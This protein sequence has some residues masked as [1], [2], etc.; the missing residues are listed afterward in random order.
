MSEKRPERP[1]R[2]DDAGSRGPCVPTAAVP[3]RPALFHLAAAVG[4]GAARFARLRAVAL[5]PLAAADAALNRFG[6]SPLNPLYQTGAIAALAFLWMLASGVYLLFLYRVGAPYESIEA[7]QAQAFAGR[8]LRALHR[9]AADAAVIAVLL[10]VFRMWA[11]GRSFGPRALAWCSGLVLL[12]A[13]LLSGWTGYVMVWDAPAL[14]LARE[15]ARLLDALPI[16][17]EP[18]ARTFSG[19]RPMPSAFFFLNLFAHVAVPVGMAGLL[20]AHVARLAR[21]RLLPPRSLAIALSLAL[22][23]LALL[24]PSPLPPRAEPLALPRDVPLDAFYAFWL[25]LTQ[26]LEPGAAWALL[27]ALALGAASAPWWT[28]PGRGER[29]EPSSVDPHLCTGC[30][31]CSLDCPFDAIAMV[32][33]E[34]AAPGRSARFARVDP[35]RCVACGICAGSCAPMAVGPPGRTGRDQLAAARQLLHDGGVSTGDVV[36][37]AC[38]SGAGAPSE[39]GLAC[40]AI[41]CAGNLHSSLVELLVRSGV[42]GVLVASCPPRDCRS[43]EGPK[44]LGERLFHDREAELHARVPRER[45][46]VV[47]ASAG[48]P[49][50]L[51]EALARFRAELAALARARPE[52]AVAL[53]A[54]CEPPAVEA[55]R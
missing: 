32:D 28:R 25:P 22:V 17:A 6:G 49:E 34:N 52:R 8:W 29:A 47:H 41:D 37:V 53:D 21:P 20:L 13:L 39:P 40:I 11:Q 4:F 7:I 42:A 35:A 48:E 36:V 26:R 1:R 46:R 18:L 50:V 43:R 12:G 55:R 24:V 3:V 14:V 16:F 31:Q 45:V 38:R 44:W 33:R 30:E 10:H 23:A 9:Y 15:G 2:T 54:E 19:E 5:K 27:G 51:R